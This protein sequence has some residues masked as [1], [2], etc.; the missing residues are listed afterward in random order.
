MATT[1]QVI[2]QQDLKNLGKSGELVSV[3]PGFA[4][5]FLVPRSLA[6]P[7]TIHN[8]KQIEHEQRLSLARSQKARGE[9]VAL[10]EKLGGVTVTLERK[11]GEENRLFGSITTKDVAVALKEKGFEVDRKRIE[12]PEVRTTGSFTV[13]VQLL[14]EVEAKVKLE[15]VAKK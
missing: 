8:V 11:V 14:G 12:L 4:R 10:A 2:L 5:N 1:I 6:V 7:A 3:R 15:V 9:A 13:S